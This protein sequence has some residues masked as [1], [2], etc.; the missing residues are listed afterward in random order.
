VRFEGIQGSP[1]SDVVSDQYERWMYLPSLDGYVSQFTGDA[2]NYGITLG[3][4]MGI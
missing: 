2:A 4:R 3:F 1:L